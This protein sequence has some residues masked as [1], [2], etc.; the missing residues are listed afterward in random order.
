MT[1]CQVVYDAFLARI[2]EDDWPLWALDDAK[3]D[4]HALLNAAIP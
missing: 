1:S 3:K 2:L 4:W